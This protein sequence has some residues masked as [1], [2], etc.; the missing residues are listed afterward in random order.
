MISALSGDD[1]VQAAFDGSGIQESSE[2]RERILSG[3]IVIKNGIQYKVA[4]FFSV[5]R[6]FPVP[7]SQRFRIFQQREGFGGKGI[8]PGKVPQWKKGLPG[9]VRLLFIYPGYEWLCEIKKARYFNFPSYI[10]L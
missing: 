7:L 4:Q 10:Y 5:V 2:I 9:R 6:R 8:I 3:T 1:I